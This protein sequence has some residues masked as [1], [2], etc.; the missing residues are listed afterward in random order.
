M[1]K[2]QSSATKKFQD[3]TDTNYLDSEISS[4]IWKVTV[5]IKKMQ[6]SSSDDNKILQFYFLWLDPCC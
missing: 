5:W 3:N 4:K 1:L 2:Y 6:L